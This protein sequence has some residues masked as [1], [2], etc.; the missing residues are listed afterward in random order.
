MSRLKRLDKVAYVRFASV[1][2][3]FKDV[4]EF[5]GELKSLLKERS[6]KMNRELGT[7]ELRLLP[8]TCRKMSSPSGNPDVLVE[9]HGAFVNGCN[10]QRQ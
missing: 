1:Y 2:L 6:K 8:N 3:D 9:F 4:K 5:M 10:R 7:I